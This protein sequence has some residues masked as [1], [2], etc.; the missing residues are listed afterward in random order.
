[1]VSIVFILTAL[2][3]YA[4]FFKD[5]F[6][7]PEYIF[8]LGIATIFF[9]VLFLVSTIG[10]LKG[11]KKTVEAVY[12]KDTL[13]E[14]AE[15]CTE[16]ITTVDLPKKQEFADSQG[17]AGIMLSAL[18]F[19]FF[20]LGALWALSYRQDTNIG[21]GFTIPTMPY[22]QYFPILAI[23]SGIS[24]LSMFFFIAIY[25]RS[26]PVVVSLES[27]NQTEYSKRG[28]GV[29]QIRCGS[30][31]TMNNIDSVYCK[32][33]AN[34]VN[35]SEIQCGSCGAKNDIDALYCKKCAN[36]FR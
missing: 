26:K 28:V 21:L 34:R 20:L 3:V 13:E 31:G 5:G 25:Y 19:V 11:E 16:T 15:T 10:L 18:A 23:A 1:M 4:Y 27:S 12:I 14:P 8:Y 9:A 30:C 2:V 29:S 36:R 24:L 6:I 35:I 17:S 33:C 32:K 22:V 7:K